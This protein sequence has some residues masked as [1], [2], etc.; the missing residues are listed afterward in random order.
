MAYPGG[1]CGQP[2]SAHY[3]DLLPLWLH[4]KSH[5]MMM[6]QKDIE[7]AKEAALELIPAGASG[8]QSSAAGERDPRP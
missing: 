1:Q 6:D 2:F 7:Q 5:P 4:G 8:E 3:R